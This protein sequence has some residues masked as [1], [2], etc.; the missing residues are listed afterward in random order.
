MKKI[1]SLL[2]VFTFGLSSCEKDDICDANT[3]TTPRLVI[4]FYEIKEPTK[5]KNVNNLM[6]IGEG[7][8]TGII[9]NKSV[10]DTTKYVANGNTISIPL[11]TD[12]LTTTYKFVYNSLS[13]NAA[14]RNTDII[15]FNYTHQNVYVSRACGFKTTFLL[16][17]AKPFEQTDPAGDGLWMQQIFVKTLNVESENETHIE[18]YF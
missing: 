17:A 3:P 14:A 18:V 9:F 6:V 1:I 12:A 10:A 4:S 13:T 8:T 11:K 16:D 15:K 5:T 2:L 7:Q